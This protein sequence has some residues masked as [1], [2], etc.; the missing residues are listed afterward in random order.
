MVTWS[1]YQVPVL[2]LNVETV[3]HWNRF[4]IPKVQAKYFAADFIKFTTDETLDAKGLSRA[5]N[6][7]NAVSYRLPKTWAR[8]TLVVWLTANQIGL[9]AH[10][11]SLFAQFR[12]FAH[13]STLT[14]WLPL[15][16]DA[17]SRGLSQDC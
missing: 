15:W 1:F 9:V 4:G 6:C 13:T 11:R 5:F 3:S 12:R 8:T 14:S 16:F 2:Y 10:R 7:S 17:Q